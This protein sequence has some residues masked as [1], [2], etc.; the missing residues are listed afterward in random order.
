MTSGS[1]IRRPNPSPTYQPLD[2]TGPIHQ[3][4]SP[5]PPSILILKSNGFK[6][7]YIVITGE[8]AIQQ[9]INQSINQS[10][11]QPR[12]ILSIPNQSIN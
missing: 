2:Q 7:D 9:S 1:D 12:D 8:S 3:V 11:Y 10:T 4:L 6:S 5:A